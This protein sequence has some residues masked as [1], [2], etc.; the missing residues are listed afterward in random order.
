M[1][2]PAHTTSTNAY[3]LA[4]SSIADGSAAENILNTRRLPV[5]RLRYADLGGRENHH[6]AQ[7]VHRP[8]SLHNPPHHAT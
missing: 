4:R 8:N 1:N 3:L 5:N 6:L 2:A 7:R